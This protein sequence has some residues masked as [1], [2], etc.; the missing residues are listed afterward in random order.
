MP[1]TDIHA[2]D[3]SDHNRIE[4]T[5][6]LADACRSSERTRTSGLVSI[7]R[8]RRLA[9]ETGGRAPNTVSLIKGVAMC[10]LAQRLLAQARGT[11]VRPLVH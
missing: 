7:Q 9:V 5:D 4:L 1:H 2:H 6:K 3:D 10:A 11:D 8:Q